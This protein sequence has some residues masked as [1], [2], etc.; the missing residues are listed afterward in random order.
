MQGEIPSRQ[1]GIMSTVPKPALQHDGADLRRSNLLPSFSGM[2]MSAIGFEHISAHAQRR[3][4]AAGFGYVREDDFSNYNRI[5]APET[6]GARPVE[7]G[8]GVLVT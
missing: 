4:V 2:P 1:G 6:A 5:H 8:S 7:P 3:V